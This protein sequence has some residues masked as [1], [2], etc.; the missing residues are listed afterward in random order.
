MTLDPTTAESAAWRHPYLCPA[1]NQ[2]SGVHE[3]ATGISFCAICETSWIARRINV[4]GPAPTGK[5][6]I[7]VE[8]SL[9]PPPGPWAQFGDE[10]APPCPACGA[11][12]VPIAYGYPDNDLMELA[13]EGRVQLGGCVIVGEDPTWACRDCSRTFRYDL[14]ACDND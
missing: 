10:P 3:F 13:I 7:A 14:S 2:R 12:L 5:P 4:L 8:V 6:P 11:I 1:C 9:V